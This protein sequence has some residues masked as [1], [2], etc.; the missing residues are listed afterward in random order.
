MARSPATRGVLATSGPGATTW[1]RAGG[2]LSR[3]H[4]VVA[5]TG[6]V[7][8]G[9]SGRARFR[10]WTRRDDAA[11][12]EACEMVREAGQLRAALRRGLRLQG[13]RAAGRAR[14]AEGCVAGVVEEDF[15]EPRICTLRSG[16]RA[17]CAALGRD[18]SVR[19]FI[20][21]WGGERLCS[22]WGVGS[23]TGLMPRWL[24]CELQ[25]VSSRVYLMG[26]GFFDSGT[27]IPRMLGITGPLHELVMREADLLICFGGRFDDGP[28]VGG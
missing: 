1:S 6:Q 24:G 9:C 23:R 7:P 25:D 2:C 18:C 17:R 4:S 5:I 8:T 19:R 10:K 11:R 13:G 22:T 27:S 14:C 12:C 28:W 16:T 20:S 15:D 26:L 3:L 21:C